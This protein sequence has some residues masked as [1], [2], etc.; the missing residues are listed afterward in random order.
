MSERDLRSAAELCP[1]S[2]PACGLVLLIEPSTLV[3]IALGRYLGRHFGAVVTAAG[4]DQV[5]SS[6]GDFSPT[7]LVCAGSV[8]RRALEWRARW[9]LERL[10]VL[11]GA[12][13]PVDAVPGVDAVLPKPVDPA[14]LVRCLLHPP[15][16]FGALI[17][18]GP[19]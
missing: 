13:E 12:V 9:S 1:R 18:G 8:A 2:E 5:G 19:W 6:L 7:H 14:A 16:G 17:E 15:P 10:V 11:S 3:R 4:A